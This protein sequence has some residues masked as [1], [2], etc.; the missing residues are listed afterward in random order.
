MN[1]RIGKYY[2]AGSNS[3]D[4]DSNDSRVITAEGNKIVM[5]LDDSKLWI[6]VQPGDMVGLFIRGNQLFEIAS[7]SSRSIYTY[8]ANLRGPLSGF[9]ARL[10]I[11]PA[12]HWISRVAPLVRAVTDDDGKYRANYPFC[13]YHE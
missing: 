12:F 4:K 8:I 2:L 9:D 10:A 1:K 7:R 5:M 13:E 11:D 6:P 3:F